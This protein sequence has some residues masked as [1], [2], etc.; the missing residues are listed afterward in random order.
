MTL[1]KLLTNI[2]GLTEVSVF[3]WSVNRSMTNLIASGA[4]LDLFRTLSTYLLE[5]DIT[6]IS[7]NENHVMCTLKAFIRVK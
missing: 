1:Y 2:D 5:C 7:E 4:A 6:N 3:A